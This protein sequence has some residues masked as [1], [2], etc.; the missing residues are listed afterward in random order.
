MSEK[1]TI[2]SDHDPDDGP[3][4]TRELAER[5]EWAVG[6]HVIRAATGTVTRRGRPPKPEEE[7]KELVS[8]R[9]SPD[10]LSW[11]RASGPGWQSRIDAL[12]RKHIDAAQAA[13]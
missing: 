10:V 12:L 8:L 13:E 4:L 1:S 6:G 5:A 9:L 2:S 11:F 3:R 7:R